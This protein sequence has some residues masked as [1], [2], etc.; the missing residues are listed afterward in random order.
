[1]DHYV[2]VRRMTNPDLMDKAPYLTKRLRET[3]SHMQERQI[4]GWLQTCCGYNEFYFVRSDKAFILAQQLRDFLDNRPTVKEIFVFAELTKDNHPEGSD[5]AK[6]QEEQNAI[7]LFEA[8]SLYE[9]VI[10]WGLSIGAQELRL[11]H[12]CDVPLGDKG[13]KDPSTRRVMFEKQ[14]LKVYKAE[15]LFANLDESQKIRRPA[16]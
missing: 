14:G 2:R 7:A 12:C 4:Y 13:T 9:G 10:R 15:E 5:A 11:S 3:Y 1:M 16:A 6:Y 8:A